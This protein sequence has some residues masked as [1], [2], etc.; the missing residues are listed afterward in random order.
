M[1]DRAGRL[2]Q[3]NPMSTPT[4]P[5]TSS[6]A[7]RAAARV[8]AREQVARPKDPD[9][10]PRLPVALQFLGAVIV[11]AHV[12]FGRDDFDIGNR[13]FAVV[14]ILPLLWE[15]NRFHKLPRGSQMP[16]GAYAMFLY[17]VTFSFPALFN[18]V[19]ADLSGPVSFSDS[20]RFQGTGSVALSSML[21]YA[22][23]R[24]GEGLGRKLQPSLLRIYPPAEIPDSY[25]RAVIWYAMAC[26]AWTQFV[27]LGARLPAAVGLLATMIFSFS[28]VIGAVMTKPESFRGRWSRHLG[29][30]VIVFGTLSGLL[31]GV[32]EPLFRLTLAAI[33]TRWVQLRR[34]SV[35]LVVVM[36]AVYVVFQP[37]KAKFRQQTWTVR[38]SEQVAGYSGRVDAWAFAFDDLWS[39]RDAGESTSESAVSRFLELD[40]ILHAFTML[41]G[42]VRSANGEAWVNILYAPIPRFLWPDKPTSTDLDQNYSVAFN[43]QNE[44]GARS[45]SI[46]LPLVVDGYWNFGWPG[47]AF[48]SLMTGLWV[49]I[50]QTMFSGDHWALKASAV[51]L[52]SLI[53]VTSSFALAFSGIS[54]QVIGVLLASW[55]VYWLARFLRTKEPSTQRLRVARRPLAGPARSPSFDRKTQPR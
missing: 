20:A 19:F 52:F 42:R 29:A 1:N 22:G 38:G 55:I 50:C 15:I 51:A 54:Q 39:S 40:P 24:L 28:Y 10:L 37:A 25:G 8:R 7:R 17:Y 2:T 53:T 46:M 43:R 6:P 34:F 9:A 36:L 18:T 4:P 30:A 31:R 3:D 41:P 26:A 11:A 27:T 35:A 44:I 49:G 48:V 13:L 47:I 23:V 14:P 21:I 12:F 5:A 45:T 32:I 16:F 33:I